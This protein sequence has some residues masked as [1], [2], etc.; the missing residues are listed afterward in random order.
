MYGYNDVTE[1]LIDSVCELSESSVKDLIEDILEDD[2][3]SSLAIK[4][5]RDAL[6]YYMKTISIIDESDIAIENAQ[7]SRDAQES[8]CR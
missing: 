5:L 1:L 6:N 8:I 4:E 3:S 2:L 7:R